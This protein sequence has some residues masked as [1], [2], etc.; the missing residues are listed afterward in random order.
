VT[1]LLAAFGLAAGLV[2][3]LPAAGAAQGGPSAKVTVSPADVVFASPS[4]F[5]FDAGWVDHGGVTITVEPKNRN[6][7]NWQLFVQASAADM[8]GYGKPVQDIMVRAQGSASW[9]PL[10]TT[11]QM[12]AEGTGTTT[13][14]LYYRLLLDWS[15]DAPGAYSVPLEYTSTSF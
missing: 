2:A 11:A 9:I 15:V 14:T 5:D 10:G 6:R 4:E 13:V 8:G 3:A 12:I 1:R 7:Q